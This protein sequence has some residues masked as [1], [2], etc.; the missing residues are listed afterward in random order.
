MRTPFRCRGDPCGLLRGR[1]FGRRLS[2]PSGRSE[3][4]WGR[5]TCP[6]GR[7]PAPQT[8]C[9]CGTT[10]VSVGTL[11][12]VVSVVSVLK[13][14]YPCKPLWSP[15]LRRAGTSP[16]PTT[17]LVFQRDFAH[18]MLSAR[19]ASRLSLRTETLRCAQGDRSP[20]PVLRP[21]ATQV[22]LEY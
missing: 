6:P 20:S 4:G 16:T 18:V 17:H 9:P 1:F 5:I 14:T 2:C 10:L 11:V 15:D 7:V 12:S 22:S 21:C 8:G 19:E 3:V 13:K